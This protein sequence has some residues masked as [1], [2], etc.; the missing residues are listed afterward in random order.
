MKFILFSLLLWSGTAY[1]TA[2]GLICVKQ[3][4][5]LHGS[6]MDTQITIAD[7]WIVS[8]SSVQPYGYINVPFVP[9]SVTGKPG[10]DVNLA[11]LYHIGIDTEE[12]GK[13]NKMEVVIDA[14][15]AKVPDGYPF[16]IEQVI[17]AMT[18]CVKIMRPIRPEDEEKFSVRVVRH[19]K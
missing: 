15:A 3:P 5:Y 12:D 18:T 13:G 10:T 1:G 4:I 19:K 2:L 11:S 16:S 6:D 9:P 7:V 8:A 14:S 17:D